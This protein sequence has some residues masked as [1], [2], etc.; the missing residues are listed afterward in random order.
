[1]IAPT[2][3]PYD[4]TVTVR[5]EELTQND[6]DFY[7]SRILTMVKYAGIPPPDVKFKL[8]ASPEFNLKIPKSFNIHPSH[9]KRELAPVLE[10]VFMS[11][12]PLLRH[13]QHHFNVEKSPELEL[14]E[15]RDELLRRNMELQ[16]K[17]EELRVERD[18]LLRKT[19][20]L[21]EQVIELQDTQ[22][23]RV[24]ETVQK[25]LRSF[26]TVLTQNC[27]SALAP[28]KIQKG[29][30]KAHGKKVDLIPDP[31][32]SKNLMVFGLPEV[33]AES[34]SVLKCEI[35][36]VLD[37][38]DEKPL[39][40]AKRV[41]LKRQGQERPV[42]VKLQSREMLLTLLQKAKQL[43]QSESYG[44]VYLSRDM[45]LAERTERRELHRTLKE[46]RES[47]PERQ[48]RIRKGAINFL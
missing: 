16:K 28:K 27:R 35:E 43:K 24:T 18:D 44:D 40:V 37:E 42:I 22:L 4:M 45:S 41:G 30:E 31:D 21:Q 20:R 46:L 25:D 36:K 9:T 38:L 15:E 34:E 32:R 12:L 13:F 7:S 29:E 23:H 48:F 2:G 39:V 6:L 47:N 14:R 1:M 33:E 8:N 3:R 5:Q 17:E 26:S 11:I 19:V 10:D